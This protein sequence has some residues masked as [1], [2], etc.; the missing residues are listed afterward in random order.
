MTPDQRQCIR[1][2]HELVQAD[3]D[4]LKAER[5]DILVSL[6]ESH[7]EE[8]CTFETVSFPAILNDLKRLTRNAED[9][10]RCLCIY[11]ST[12]WGSML[13]P[14][15]SAKFVTFCAP[16]CPNIFALTACCC[17]ETLSDSHLAGGQQEPLDLSGLCTQMED[18][19]RQVW[20]IHTDGR[21]DSS[22]ISGVT[23]YMYSS[24]AGL[25]ST[26]TGT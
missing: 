6:V 13:S 3:M 5:G 10:H 20:R 15:Q 21:E 9:I 12:L 2:V 17:D 22:P 11:S 24:L 1:K 26:V 7:N 8:E 14:L 25:P 19:Y 16:G 18:R 4:R 23:D